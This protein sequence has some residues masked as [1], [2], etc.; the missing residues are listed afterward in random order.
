MA[1]QKQP[2]SIIPL[3][4]GCRMTKKKYPS[5][6]SYM[7]SNNKGSMPDNNM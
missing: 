5:H 2:S 4:C 3:K 1:K 7:T 6:G